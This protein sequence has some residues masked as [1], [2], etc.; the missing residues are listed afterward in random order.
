MSFYSILVVDDE[1]DIRELIIEALEVNDLELKIYQA[2]DGLDGLNKIRNQKFDL[3]ISDLKMP[4]LGGKD[5]L[6]EI[7]NIHKDFKPDNIIVASG[8]VDKEILKAEGGVSVLQKPF[9]SKNLNHYVRSI[10]SNSDKNIS[11]DN[12]SRLNVEIINPFIDA[13]IDVLSVMANV[14]AEKDHIFIKKNSTALGDITGIIPISSKK[15]V[16]SM[17]ITF[18]EDVFLK[19][20]SSMLDEELTQID[21]ENKDG[22]AEICNQIFGNAKAKLNSLGYF[23]DMTIPS[24][25][26]GKN[27]SI[28]HHAKGNV[29][30]VKFKTVFGIF[31]IE[32]VIV[33][34][35][36]K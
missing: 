29:M 7:K 18:T 34:K 1:S 5:F 36:K 20:M 4:K 24:I 3:V 27:H 16:G 10:L 6:K 35:K 22:I 13:T 28:S 12:S 17:S 32:C 26:H 14:E 21:D 8:F 11:K 19:I 9:T 15:N 30:G 33:N 31:I 2:C 25:I 23:L